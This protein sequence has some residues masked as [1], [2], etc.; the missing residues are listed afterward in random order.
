MRRRVNGILVVE[1]S[2]REAPR[3][4]VSYRLNPYSSPKVPKFFEN[5]SMTTD[6]GKTSR[7]YSIPH[8]PAP[9][10]VK[11]SSTSTRFVNIEKRS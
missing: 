8:M 7:S 2:A 11:R 3:G 4:S 5:H 1:P 6:S 9:H 10:A